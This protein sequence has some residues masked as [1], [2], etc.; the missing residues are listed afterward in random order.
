[1]FFLLFFLSFYFCSISSLIFKGFPEREMINFYNET[2]NMQIITYLEKDDILNYDADFYLKIE[3]YDIPNLKVLYLMNENRTRNL[4][5]GLEWD[6]TDD[7]RYMRIL[8]PVPTYYSF[9]IMNFTIRNIRELDTYIWAYF[10]KNRKFDLE[11]YT[12]KAKILFTTP[13]LLFNGK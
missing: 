9:W 8:S 4:T 13:S 1:M 5:Y 10:Y 2:N 7:L 6:L 11:N 3:F 12:G